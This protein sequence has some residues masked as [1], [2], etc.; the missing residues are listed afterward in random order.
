MDRF[1]VALVAVVVV[2]VLGCGAAVF[3]AGE[4]VPGRA[5]AVVE[6]VPGPATGPVCALDERYVDER[7]D[8]LPPAVLSAWRSLVRAADVDLCLNDGKRSRD[9]QQREFDEAVG[10]FGNAELASRYVLPPSKSM[11]VKGFAVDVQP[12][13]SAAWVEANGESLG[14]CRRYDN[15]PWHFEYKASYKADGCPDLEP[16]ATGD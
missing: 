3:L 14:W 6:D 11:H 16:S 15:E 10:K 8:G 2:A 5:Q 9:Q 7:P 12:L 4:V 13:S 1:L